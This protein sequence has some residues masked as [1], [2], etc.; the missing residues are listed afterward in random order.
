MEEQ[1]LLPPVREEVDYLMAVRGVHQVD[2][3]VVEVGLLARE[4]ALAIIKLAAMV[5]QDHLLVVVELLTALCQL[6]TPLKM[7][8]GKALSLTFH[9]DLFPVVAGVVVLMVI[10]LLAAMV[11][12]VVVVV[13]VQGLAVR[14]VSAVAAAG[15]MQLAAAAVDLVVVA[16]VLLDSLAALVVLLAAAAA[17]A[18]LVLALAV[19]VASFF[20]GLRGIKNEIRMD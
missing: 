3:M 8:L 6:F 5:A 1:A 14:V 10:L 15:A 9:H 2:K 18:L 13:A 4:E 16:V 17:V 11:A 20:I 7:V 19:S 12:P